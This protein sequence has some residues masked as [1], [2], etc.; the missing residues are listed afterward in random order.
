MMFEIMGRSTLEPDKEFPIFEK[1]L[2]TIHEMRKQSR[3]E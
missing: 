3:A 1:A 2:D